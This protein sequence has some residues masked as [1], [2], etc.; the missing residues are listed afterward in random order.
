MKLSKFIMERLVF[1]L[2]VLIGL[3]ILI[4]FIARVVPGD[5]VRLALGARAPDEVVQRMRDEM[6]L[7][8]PIYIQYFFWFKNI[9]KGDFG[10][11]LLTR[12]DVFTDIKEF[13]PA[14][15]ELALVAGLIMSV[16]GILLGSVAAQFKNS[17]IDNGVRVF[18]YIGVVTPAFVFA[19]LFVLLFGYVFELLP[20]AGRLTQGL[21]P[22]TRITGMML[23]DS[24][25]TGNFTVFFDALQHIILPAVSLSIAGMAQQS[26]ITRGSMSDNFNKDYILAHKTYG[27]PKKTILFKYILKPSLIPTVSILGLDFAALLGNA[28]L[29]ELVFNWPGLSRYGINA[30]LRKDLNV[31]I[32]VVMILGVTFITVNIIVDI[33]VAYLDPRIR[34]GREGK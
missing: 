16:M 26:R 18:S 6:H 15:L 14:T 29:V 22:P 13:L 4:F 8:D 19:V 31:V 33:I 28:F 24:L 20:T 32:A 25:L 3:S 10:K 27:I 5:P 9:L 12:Q 21:I 7:N 23:I 17:W 30:I 34:M 2:V 1:S 11:S